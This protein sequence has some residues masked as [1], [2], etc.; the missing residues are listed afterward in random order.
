M[1]EMYITAVIPFRNR[2]C[3]VGNNALTDSD[4]TIKKEYF[5]ALF[6]EILS[7]RDDY[8]E[9]DVSSVLLS[10]G[11]VQCAETPIYF[12]TVG[13]IQRTFHLAKKTPVAV[14][15]DPWDLDPTICGFISRLGNILPIVRM[16][17]CVRDELVAIGRAYPHHSIDEAV[18]QLRYENVQTAGALLYTGLPG[19]TVESLEYSVKQ[20]IENNVVHLTIE[21][22]PPFSVIQLLS[23]NGYKNYAQ[24]QFAKEGW[25]L[26][27]F[28]NIEHLGFGLG[29]VSR[30]DGYE[31]V[32][33][34]D[35][36]KYC[37]N[38]EN[39][40]VIIE[41]VKEIILRP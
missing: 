14:M 3:L 35:M 38:S 29:A 18:R 23:D 8:P 32:S 27:C 6:K 22:D 40:E 10:G 20:C 41:S 4:M 21:S 17:S 39:M 15:V 5:D 37:H 24:G 2:S 30:I 7:A 11:P 36:E 12:E 19:Q 9:Y 1:K 34:T 13:K 33:T 31:T 28:K 16:Y 25:E 26:S